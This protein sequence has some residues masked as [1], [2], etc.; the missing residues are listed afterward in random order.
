MYF[1]YNYL[2][3]TPTDFVKAREHLSL[4]SNTNNE[5][6]ECIPKVRLVPLRVCSWFGKTYQ[7]THEKK[8]QAP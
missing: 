2:E 4:N 1:H 8:A 6:W 7:A 3:V 5:K